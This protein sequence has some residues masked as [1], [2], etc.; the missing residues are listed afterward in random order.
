M[1]SQGQH[2]RLGLE[3]HYPRNGTVEEQARFLTQYTVLAPSVRNSQPWTFKV[4]G[5]VISLYADRSKHLPKSDPDQRQLII[6]CGAALHHLCTAA[7]HFGH[8]VQVETFPGEPDLLADIR[9]AGS[10][11]PLESET[12][13][14]YAIHKETVVPQPFRVERK[15]PQALLNEL[16]KIGNQGATWLHLVQERNARDT[17]AEL[18][19]A[20]DRI[21]YRDEAFRRELA[22]WIS[23]ANKKNHHYGKGFVEGVNY[24]AS[25]VESFLIRSF[26]NA[27]SFAKADWQLAETAPVLAILGTYEND[28]RDWLATGETLAAVLLRSL[29]IGVHASFLNQPV[30]VPELCRKL[31]S[32]LKLPGDPQMLFCLG[33]PEPASSGKMKSAAE[34]VRGGFI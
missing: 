34:L 33:Y 11:V 9:L 1:A 25:Y 15:V 6:S 3:D 12:I 21:Q 31:V 19:A 23:P 5:N 8:S 28:S 18:V 14:F 16:V 32:E 2:V 20:G 24:V 26:P 7:R 17:V 27:D 4:L 13:M 29:A 30:E 10:A 22:E